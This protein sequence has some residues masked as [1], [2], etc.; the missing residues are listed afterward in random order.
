[1]E[2]V[3]TSPSGIAWLALIISII[4]LVLAWNAFNR[5]GKDL[6]VMVQEEVNTAVMKAQQQA[7]EAEDEARDAAADTLNATASATKDAAK[8]VR[9]DDER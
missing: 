4:A 6:E 8:D 1:M 9:T 2:T 5:A 7:R 3:K